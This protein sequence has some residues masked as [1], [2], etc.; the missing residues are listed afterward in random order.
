[1][2]RNVAALALKL[3]SYRDLCGPTPMD[4]VEWADYR[5]STRIPQQFQPLA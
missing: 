4:I 2:L 3:Y 1:M 5:L